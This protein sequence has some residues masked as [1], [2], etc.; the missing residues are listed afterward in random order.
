MMTT[1]HANAI[2]DAQ[3]DRLDTDLVATIVGF[4][5]GEERTLAEHLEHIYESAVLATPEQ[6]GRTD[7][8]GEKYLFRFVPHAVNAHDEEWLPTSLSTKSM[9]LRIQHRW[10]K[11][12]MTFKVEHSGS[13][14]W[15]IADDLES[16]KR[17]I[18]LTLWRNSRVAAHMRQEHATSMPAA[19][20][21][22]KALQLR[23]S[24]TGGENQPTHAEVRAGA[25]DVL[26]NME[27]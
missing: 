13:D 25:N 11:Y 4:L 12:G 18:A 14:G 16:M 3:P 6:K 26:K 27:L 7:G 20:F 22:E 21:L 24:E 23:C 8:D 2:I 10:W 5:P 17:H 15:A 1:A 19:W 9:C